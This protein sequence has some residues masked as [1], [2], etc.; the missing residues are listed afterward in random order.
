MIFFYYF[1]K[2]I[3]FLQLA[4]QMICPYGDG[5]E[6]FD[7]DFLLNRHAQVVLFI[8]LNGWY[9]RLKCFFV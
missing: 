5:D 8:F 7:V 1:L 3:V 4:E 6:H 9:T 2:L